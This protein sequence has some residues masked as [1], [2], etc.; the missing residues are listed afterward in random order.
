[1]VLNAS[2]RAD[3]E[4]PAAPVVRK[5]ARRRQ[6]PPVQ[7]LSELTASELCPIAWGIRFQTS[8]QGMIRCDNLNLR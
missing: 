1:M 6:F 3:L 7:I 2:S 5:N 8:I 4:E